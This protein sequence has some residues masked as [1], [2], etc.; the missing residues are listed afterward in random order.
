MNVKMR[1]VSKKNIQI[2]KKL[3]DYINQYYC[4]RKY[5]TD[6]RS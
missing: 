6:Q 2:Y 4:Y 3:I 5:E 1:C